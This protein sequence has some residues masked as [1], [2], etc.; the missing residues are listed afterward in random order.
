MS[1]RQT[2]S[3]LRRRFQ[4]AG[5]SPD[6]RKG[7]SFLIDLNLLEILADSAALSPRDV[8]LEV[9]TGTGSLTSLLARGAGA[10]VSVEVDPRLHQLAREELRHE[11][12]V[13]LLCLDALKNKNK[14]Q[15]ELLQL[16]QRRMEEIPGSRFKLAANLPYNVATPIISN[17]LIGPLIPLSM[18]V[19]IQKEMAD[20]LLAPPGIKDYG[21]LSI[22]VQSQCE[23]E[24]IR[25]LP[26][27]VFWPRPKVHSTILQIRPLPEMRQALPD[28]EFFQAFTR[29][30][31]C[32]RRKLLRN[33]L[34]TAHRELG[35]ATID[36]VL[37]QQAL[38]SDARAEQLT[39][40]QMLA[41]SEAV[42]AR[43]AELPADGRSA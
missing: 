12:N 28:P 33:E 25:E 38:P 23:L 29:S 11:T 17:L 43:I 10:V 22:W 2:I 15:P 27:T 31:F 1:T 5:I 19:T 13:T 40:Q 41:L 24:A 30:M 21:A 18:T 3:F 9:G 37:Q 6:T 16:V 4:E 8:V 39:W 20:R 7:Q 42:R 14:L 32:H 35:K 34:V 36:G 26:P